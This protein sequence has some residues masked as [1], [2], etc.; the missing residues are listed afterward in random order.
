MVEAAS[1]QHWA[2]TPWSFVNPFFLPAAE[3]NL[4]HLWFCKRQFSHSVKLYEYAMKLQKSNG[5]FDA[6]LLTLIARAHYESRSKFNEAALSLRKHIHLCPWEKSSR[7]NLA[8]ALQGGPILQL[9]KFKIPSALPDTGPLKSIR[10]DVDLLDKAMQVY[11]GLKQIP[12]EA[13]PMK[14]ALIDEQ[15]VMCGKFKEAGSKALDEMVKILEKQ[16]IQD[17]INRKEWEEHLK[18]E[19]E[20]KRLKEEEDRRCS[21]EQDAQDRMLL[22]EREKRKAIELTSEPPNVK[23]KKKRHRDNPKPKS[24]SGTILESSHSHAIDRKDDFSSQVCKE[25]MLCFHHISRREMK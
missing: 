3:I 4:G 5:F 13:L 25:M 7:F 12:Q 17:Q 24:N 11:Q 15:M 1:L 23:P 14:N 22:V 2:T 6:T 10:K 19:A 9:H 21:E 16:V 20:K 8:L 18:R